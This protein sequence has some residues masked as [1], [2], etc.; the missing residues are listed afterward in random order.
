[1]PPEPTITQRIKA[2][3]RWREQ[4]NPL[5]GLTVRRAVSLLEAGQRGE[6]AELHWAYYFVEMT[7]P[8]L[9]ALIERRLAPLLET[10]WHI[11]TLDPETTGFDPALA[12]SQT[13]FLKQQ[14]ER[15]E[16]LYEAIEHLAMAQFR[17]YAHL[18]KTAD[19]LLPVDTWN[20]VR[21]GLTGPW[22]Y[23]PEAQPIGFSSL[24]AANLIAPENFIIR[25]IR[26]PINRWAIYKFICSNLS[27]KDWNAFVEI[28]GLPGAVVILPPNLQDKADEFRD[29]AKE[30]AEG[31]SGS[32]PNGSDVKFS[33]SPRGSS[34]FRDHL[35]FLQEQLV[36]A[37]TGGLLT[38]LAQSGS[39]TLAGG[40][41]EDTFDQ[42]AAADARKISELLQKQFDKP[43]LAQAFPG[44]PVLAYF[45]LAAQEETDIGQ[46]ID[47]A[48][49]LKSAGYQLDPEE[50]SEK[51][52]YTLSLIPSSPNPEPR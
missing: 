51:T 49:K 24:P 39:G 18:E 17:G 12:E 30:V 11:K 28:Y 42:I 26:R 27:F 43:A 5:R 21:D 23:N 46:I 15:L 13:A 19:K 38:M 48:V 31:A 50:L 8:D 44:R 45:E 16:N 7:D 47:H 34:P 9:L 40:A 36:L 10:E 4:Y 20:V 37:G 6:L 52:G 3:N 35:K 1:M 29:A 22:K 25:E 33:D 41:H 14:Y 32:L 2:A